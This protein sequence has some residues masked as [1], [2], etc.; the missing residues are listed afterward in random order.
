MGRTEAR[1]SLMLMNVP[2]PTE[3]AEDRA[4]SLADL[5]WLC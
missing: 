1:V 3:V 4:G 2:T 5:S